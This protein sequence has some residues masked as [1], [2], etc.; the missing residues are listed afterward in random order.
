VR[1]VAVD[2]ETVAPE[3]V[4]LWN[5]SAG[6]EFPLD[7]RLLRQQLALDSDPRLCL[8]VRRPDGSVAAA[9]IAK[10][11]ARPGA[12]G[13]PPKAGYLSYL[14]VDEDSRRR[15]VARGLLDEAAAWL[16]SLGAARIDVGGDFYHLLPGRPIAGGPGYAALE[17]FLRS[18]GFVGEGREYDLSADLDS[19]AWLREPGGPPDRRY[20]FEY[21]EPAYREGTLRFLGECFPGRWAGEI[22]EALSAGLRGTDLVLAIDGETGAVVGF[23]RVYD[24]DSPLLGPGVYWRRLMGERPWGLGPIGIDAS[25]RGRGLG[26]GLLEYCVRDLARRGVGTMV[27][28]WTDLVDFYGKLGFT[29]WKRYERMSKRI[30]PRA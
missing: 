22:R 7:E 1:A 25:K 18:S 21:Y 12:S 24:A 19:L 20:R 11:A 17:A 23:S 8:V 2:P 4:S 14:A 10:R 26:L 5:R 28:D 13:E 15:G 6:A 3:L 9:A 16:S 27:I 29:V 30:A